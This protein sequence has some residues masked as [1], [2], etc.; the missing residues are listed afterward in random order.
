MNIYKL[1][2]NE[3]NQI[4]GY[5][6]INEAQEGDIV[7]S[8]QD[9]E[10][11]NSYSRPNNIQQFYEME[12]IKQWLIENDYK[13]NKHTLGEYADDDLRWVEYLEQ[14]QEKL[15]RYNELESL[16][17]QVQLPVFDISLL[18]PIEVEEEII[19]EVA[20]EEVTEE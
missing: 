15:L 19:E 11:V 9:L 6:K 18:T 12:Q 8:D 14:R 20:S 17:E 13:I 7:F 3:N 10:L 2:L 4:T 1:Y 16:L 5:S